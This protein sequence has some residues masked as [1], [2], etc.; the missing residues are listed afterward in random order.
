[1][2]LQFLR[3][4]L[5]TPN[6]NDKTLLQITGAVTSYIIILIQFNLAYQ[7]TKN[8]TTGNSTISNTTNASLT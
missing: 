2:F 6:E 4:Y 1:M 8:S 5:V 7:R 3:R